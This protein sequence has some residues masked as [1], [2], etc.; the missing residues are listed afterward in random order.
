MKEK[1]NLRYCEEAFPV[2]EFHRS[3]VRLA[4]LDKYAI[5]TTPVLVIWAFDTSNAREVPV[6]GNWR[7]VLFVHRA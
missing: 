5:S 6:I 4:R 1:Q 3:E 2:V 7:E